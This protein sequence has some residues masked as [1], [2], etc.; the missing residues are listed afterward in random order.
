MIMSIYERERQGDRMREERRER[1]S[2]GL[3]ENERG[4]ERW[5]EGGRE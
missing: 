2:N 1:E 4:N 3:R 5:I